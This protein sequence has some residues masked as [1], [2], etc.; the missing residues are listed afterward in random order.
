MRLLTGL[1]VIF[2]LSSFAAPVLAKERPIQLSRFRGVTSR[3]LQASRA[4]ESLINRRALSGRTSN[5]IPI[6]EL[7][8][9][10]VSLDESATLT[11]SLRLRVG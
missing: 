6:P 5:T 1:T 7:E 8:M 3:P 4:A 11:R 2:A 9:S 10:L